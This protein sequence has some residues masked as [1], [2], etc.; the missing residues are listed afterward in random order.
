MSNISTIRT[1]SQ[2]SGSSLSLSPSHRERDDHYAKVIVQLG[3]RWRIIVCKDSHQWVLQKRSV[4]PPNTGTWAGKSYATT[5]GGL[6]AACSGRGLL[7]EAFAR[8][9]LEALPSNVR[10]FVSQKGLPRARLDL[11]E[12]K[13]TAC[14]SNIHEAAKASST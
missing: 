11:P 13:D 7:S 6:I 14:L 9:V 10:D 1:T 3:P 4:A 8:Q 2:N 12:G 5:R